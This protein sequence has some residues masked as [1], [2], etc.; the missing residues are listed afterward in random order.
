V[1]PA[2]LTLLHNRKRRR[3]M[4]DALARLAR[5]DAAQA[6]ATELHKLAGSA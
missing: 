1:A 3:D 6:I 2:L 5:P 4:E